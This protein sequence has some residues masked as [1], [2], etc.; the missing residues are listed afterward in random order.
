M[1]EA[2][3]ATKPKEEA[4]KQKTILGDGPS[5]TLD[6][7]KTI[8]IQKW[9]MRKA[10]TMTESIQEII[11]SVF[12]VFSEGAPISEEDTSGVKSFVSRIPAAAM[13][14]SESLAKIISESVIV[15]GGRSKTV[16]ADEILDWLTVADFPDVIEKI[17]ELN[18]P[19]E[20]LGKWTALITG[21]MFQRK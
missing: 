21:R 15:L 11:E 12:D 14:C 7:G 17:V 6:N 1:P 13:K 5:I 19:E 2:T 18:L 4:S 16:P 20:A 9:S 3:E 8:V 10:M